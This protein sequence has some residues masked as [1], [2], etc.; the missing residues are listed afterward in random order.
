MASLKNPTDHLVLRIADL[1]VDP[2]VDEICKDGII[3]K[4][5]PRAMRLLLCL[6]EQPGR[7][8]SV[9]QLLD[10]VWKDVVVSPDSV[11]AAVAALRRILG[12]DPKH[13]KYIANVVRR[14]YRL[15]APVSVW[16]GRTEEAIA[17][18]AD[19]QPE[20][21]ATFRHRR[22][23]PQPTVVPS[24]G[25][26]ATPG[27]GRTGDRAGRFRLPAVL[28]LVT[29]AVAAVGFT[30]HSMLKSRQ[31]PST[32]ARAETNGINASSIAVL[33]FVDMSEK[34]DQEYFGDGL[35]EELIDQLTQFTEL[36]VI[37]RT[38][39]FQF[40][41]RSDDARV[42]GAKLSVANILEG[43]VRRFEDRLRVA[44]QL[45]DASDGS[46]RWSQTYERSANDVFKVQ[47]EIAKDVVQ[48]L[49]LKLLGTLKQQQAPTE[50]I[51][52]H[53]LLLEGRFFQERWSPG[54]Q[55]VRYPPMREPSRK[56]PP[57]RLPGRSFLGQR[58]GKLGIRAAKRALES[59]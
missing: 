40:K 44:V 11:Y 57:M 30:A 54:I 47:D 58:Y 46:S 34:H 18:A 12:D 22:V 26:N 36:R 2:A 16:T 41:A 7:V 20:E 25:R 29:L 37:S 50:N 32:T 53:N 43:S 13:P 52:A 33:A 51:A 4:L 59:R 8:V 55:T 19:S 27:A 17:D 39:A 9:D 24:A 42:I 15:V 21:F 14:G 5:E 31:L 6:A 38:S 56:T 10:Q 49:K 35:A 45:V 1:R 28:G 48:A 3:L 23:E